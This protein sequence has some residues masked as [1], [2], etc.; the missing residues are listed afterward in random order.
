MVFMFLQLEVFGWDAE[1]VRPSPSRCPMPRAT[2]LARIR[3]SEQ[4]GM[5]ARSVRRSD[6]L[7]KGLAGVDK[8]RS[9]PARVSSS[10]QTRPAERCH[11]AGEESHSVGLECNLIGQPPRRTF[12]RAVVQ[13]N[14]KAPE[15]AFLH[16]R[17]PP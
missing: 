12:F 8:G 1:P 11:L 6:H 13:P 10:G 16:Q 7:V 4:R 14:W 17:G 15:R 2:Q 3:H 9:P 5:G